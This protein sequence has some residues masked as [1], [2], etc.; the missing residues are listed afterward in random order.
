MG[1]GGSKSKSTAEM[2]SE[3]VAETMYKNQMAIGQSVAI[4]QTID[5][6]GE[7]NVVK[8]VVMR[9]AIQLNADAFQNTQNLTQ[10][11]T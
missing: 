10:M 7:Y 2:V 5:V 1:V 8:D 4:Q 3:L 11:Q 6:S 9:Q